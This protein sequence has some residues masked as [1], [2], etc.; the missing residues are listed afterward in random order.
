MST[1]Y[2]NNLFPS[3]LFRNYNVAIEVVVGSNNSELAS[4]ARD[5]LLFIKFVM[6][7]GHT[8][9]EPSWCKLG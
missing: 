4:N 3:V 8:D 9:P 1:M 5:R 6:K 7:S 2:D